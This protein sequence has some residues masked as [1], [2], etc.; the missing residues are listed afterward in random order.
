MG[1]PKEFSATFPHSEA[2]LRFLTQSLCDYG[3]LVSHSRFMASEPAGSTAPGVDVHGLGKTFCPAN[4]QRAREPPTIACRY[5]P[6]L[7][8]AGP[9]MGSPAPRL[10]SL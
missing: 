2:Q 3:D 1:A 8:H 10:Y 4:S 9:E 7:V 5:M 6:D